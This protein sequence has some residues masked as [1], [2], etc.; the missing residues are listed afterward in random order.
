MGPNIHSVNPF[1]SLYMCPISNDLLPSDEFFLESLI[2]SGLLLD[3]GSIVTKSN[4]N[5]LSKL[6]ISM[7]RSSYVGIF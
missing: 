4:P 5:F 7:D 6:D 1:E 3:V 2:Q